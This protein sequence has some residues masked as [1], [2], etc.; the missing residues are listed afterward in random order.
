MEE[1]SYCI[2]IHINTINQKVYI[3][4]TCQKPESRWGI[5]GNKYQ[6]N[7]YFWSAIQKYGWENFEHKILEENLT[8]EQANE[9]EIYWI[10]FYD[11]TNREKGY[12]SQSGGNN[13]I[14][15]DEHKQKIS[16]TLTGREFSEE[17]RQ[18]ISEAAKKIPKEKRSMYGKHHT[19]EAKEKMRQAK[20]GK[21]LTEEHKQHISDAIKG[22]NHPNWGKHLSEETR[23]K[24]GKGGVICIETGK[25][26]CSSNEAA[27]D[28]GLKS[29]AHI[30]DVCRGKRKTAGKYH[31]KYAE[32]N[33]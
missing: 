13:Y 30:R 27:K 9:R 11:S 15:S 29:G 22:E 5:N 19:E 4:Q 10:S 2:Y 33:N 6:R 8:L 12:N 26:Y 24:I 3:G 14:M 17:H 32:E 18:N 23:S 20:L 7:S 25:Y 16:E 21:N 1:K 31:W 28:V